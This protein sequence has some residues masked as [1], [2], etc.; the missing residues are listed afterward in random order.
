P[1]HISSDG[2]MRGALRASAAH[3]S[4]LP[5]RRV[6][7]PDID[8]ELRDARDLSR[9]QAG[10]VAGGFHEVLVRVLGFLAADHG[11]RITR[12]LDDRILKPNVEAPDYPA[13]AT[14]NKVQRTIRHT[15]PC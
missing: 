10:D 15:S 13:E 1:R 8:E 6:A 3:N 4:Q 14:H 5:T 11:A 2:L 9:K 12:H 7:A